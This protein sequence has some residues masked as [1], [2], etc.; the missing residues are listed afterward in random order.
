MTYDI[1]SFVIGL[2]FW[3]LS[4]VVLGSALMVVVARD[5]VHAALWL[6]ASFAGVAGLYFL[7]E[8][9]FIGV[10]QILVYTGAVSI[11]VLFA[12]MLT[13]HGPERGAL[14]FERWWIAALV[15]LGLFAGVMLPTIWTPELRDPDTGALTYW[16]QVERVA[17]TA[18][19]AEGAAAPIAGAREIG[20][21]FMHE[22]YL[23]FWLGNILLLV[24]LIGAIVIAYEERARRR[25]V[26]TLAEEAELR[27]ALA[28]LTAEGAATE[29]A[30][31][32][33]AALEE[34]NREAQP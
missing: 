28:G 16:P 22:Y 27:R 8:A 23:P 29:R 11:L 9:P 21:A 24:A 19:Q 32:L 31:L 5:V 30:A 2:L 15:A 12:I 14:R 10:V 33:P 20:V 18:P 13:R 25:R 7:L 6:I 17:P 4:A 1:A 3:V 34:R 26:L